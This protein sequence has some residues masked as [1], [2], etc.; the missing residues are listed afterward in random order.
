MLLFLQRGMGTYYKKR[1]NRKLETPKDMNKEYRKCNKCEAEHEVRYHLYKDGSKHLVCICPDFGYTTLKF[2]D[3]L[4]L[5]YYK[6]SKRKVR[7]QVNGLL[8]L[9]EDGII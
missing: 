9:L 2:E 1:L 6:T 3:G 7:A 5:L 4:D 8:D